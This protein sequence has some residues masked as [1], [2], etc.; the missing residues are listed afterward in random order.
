MKTDFH[1]KYM[2]KYF[3]TLEEVMNYYNNR[4]MHMSPCEDREYQ[5]AWHMR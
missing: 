2:K 1:L 5:P 4:M 3:N